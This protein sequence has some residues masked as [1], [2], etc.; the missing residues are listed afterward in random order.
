M[1][2]LEFTQAISSKGKGIIPNTA[3]IAIQTGQIDLY[4]EEWLEQCSR[5]KSRKHVKNLLGDELF[6]A[7]QTFK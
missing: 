7:L 5:T 4:I 6:N 1:T 2:K 3:K